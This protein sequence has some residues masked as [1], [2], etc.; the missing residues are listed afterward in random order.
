[1]LYLQ[2][3]FFLLSRVYVYVFGDSMIKKI[4]CS[5]AV[6]ASICGGVYANNIGET[7]VIDAIDTNNIYVSDIYTSVVP[8]RIPLSSIVAVPNDI[9]AGIMIHVDCAANNM[10]NMRLVNS[11]EVDAFNVMYEDF[12]S[13]VVAYDTDFIDVLKQKYEQSPIENYILKALLSTTLSNSNFMSLQYNQGTTYA[14]HSI[15]DLCQQSID[16]THMWWKDRFFLQTMA[17]DIVAGTKII[18]RQ[19]RWADESLSKPL[20]PSTSTGTTNTWAGE[21]SSVNQNTR[22]NY[23]KYFQKEDNK[24]AIMYASNPDRR[25]ME[26]FPANR[27]IIHHTAGDYEANLDEGSKYMRSVQKYHV[28][29]WWWDVGYHY[30]ID[31]A[32]NIYEWR[33]W[34]MDTVGAHVL[35][36]NRWSVGISLMSDGKYS[37][38]M[39]VS[40]VE[41]TLYL[42]EQYDIDVT[43]EGM[44]KNPDVTALEEAPSVVAHKELTPLKPDDP[45]INMNLFRA[46]LKKV[47]E[48]NPG[49]VN[50]IKK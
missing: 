27:I 8:I 29:I 38:P 7:Y 50:A 31:G 22:A 15:D 35:G 36:H 37:I 44:F 40:L 10:V 48:Q 9:E 17:K 26:Y 1:M 32:G 49:L 24:K 4:V 34:G 3:Y 25:P 20:P 47:K 45:E 21:S 23:V 5:I 18:S 42:G 16:N 46:I 28:S 6:L 14:L 19:E 39:L 13:R 43:S 41:L 12:L 33:R 30:L 11:E 2:Y